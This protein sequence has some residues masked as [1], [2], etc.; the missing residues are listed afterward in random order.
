MLAQSVLAFVN[1]IF[2]PSFCQW[3]LS[4]CSR[5]CDF[6]LG[7]ENTSYFLLCWGLHWTAKHFILLRFSPI[8]FTTGWNLTLGKTFRLQACRLARDSILQLNL[9]TMAIGFVGG[10]FFPLVAAF[11]TYICA[12]IMFY[13]K[14]SHYPTNKAGRNFCEWTWIWTSLLLIPSQKKGMEACASMK[15][16]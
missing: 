12:F 2:S 3:D 1:R 14:T 8:G 9:S 11:I 15:M 16:C 10:F 4:L 6:S 5:E 13:E 7:R